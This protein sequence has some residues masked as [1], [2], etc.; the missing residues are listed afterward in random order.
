MDAGSSTAQNAKRKGGR[1]RSSIAV[2]E[3]SKLSLDGIGM[4]RTVTLGVLII[5][6][7][8]KLVQNLNKKGL[9]VHLLRVTNLHLY[10]TRTARADWEMRSGRARRAVRFNAFLFPFRSIP[11]LADT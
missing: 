1:R 7:F 2:P 11:V 9:E 8:E 4:W 3:A 6:N 5:F 10:V